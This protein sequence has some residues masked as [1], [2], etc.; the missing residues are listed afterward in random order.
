MWIHL[1]FSG[2]QLILVQLD[3]KYDV[4]YAISAGN[5]LDGDYHEFSITSDDTALL[6]AY[7]KTPWDLS[8][9]GR[10]N[11]F[12]WDCAFQEVDVETNEV[13]FE[14]RASQHYTFADMTVNSWAEWTGHDGDPWDW[15][16][17]NSVEKDSSGNYL[18]AARYT[19]AITYIKGHTGAILW[20]L[21]GKAN[22]FYNSPMLNATRFIDPHMARWSDERSAITLFD[23]IASWSMDEPR[24]ESHGIN[25]KINVPKRTATVDV[26]LL[27]P[28]HT[29]AASEGSMQ[30]LSNG[31]YFV[32]YGSASIYAEFAPNGTLLC[33]AH[34]APLGRE[35]DET[36]QGA[37]G[38][39]RIS[40]QKWVGWPE[41]PPEIKLKGQEMHVSWNGATALRGWRLAGRRIASHSWEDLGVRKRSGFETTLSLQGKS[42]SAFQLTALDERSN[43]LSAWMIQD[44][45]KITVSQST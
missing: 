36:G 24:R 31:N 3:Y 40:K 12:I 19:N 42:Y 17:L 34:Y 15:F 45:G 1:I 38:S 13:L 39:F 29:F 33:S 26:E 10:E 37:L 28:E 4:A 11:G 9:Y 7:V 5:G 6:T 16:H 35:S 2:C 22:D 44:D 43:A 25:L 23:N 21:G 30:V 8:A 32:G 14:W 20:T 41:E 18:L 27:H